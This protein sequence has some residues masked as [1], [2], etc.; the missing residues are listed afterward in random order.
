MEKSRAQ[1]ADEL[2]RLAY[3][4]FDSLA[5]NK[6]FRKMAPFQG[7]TNDIQ[8]RMVK[9]IAAIK[10]GDV[11]IEHTARLIEADIQISHATGWM[12]DETH[13]KAMNLIGDILDGIRSN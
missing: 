1:I 3:I 2:W 4:T 11:D 5:T 12:T 10:S 7:P 6:D 8:N 9:N 13:E